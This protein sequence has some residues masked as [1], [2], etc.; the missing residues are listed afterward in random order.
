MECP[1]PPCWVRSLMTFEQGWFVWNWEWRGGFRNAKESERKKPTQNKKLKKK[2]EKIF[3]T[4]IFF[5]C[6]IARNG[7]LVEFIH[8]QISSLQYLMLLSPNPKSWLLSQLK[9][10]GVGAGWVQKGKT[11]LV[12]QGGNNGATPGMWKHPKFYKRGLKLWEKKPWALQEAK[13]FWREPAREKHET[14][15]SIYPAKGNHKDLTKTFLG[16]FWEY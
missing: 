14:K 9:D 2:R 3:W 1:S 5:C 7:I 16:I 12:L 4:W 13:Q 8:A 11:W 15:L 10:S 6:H